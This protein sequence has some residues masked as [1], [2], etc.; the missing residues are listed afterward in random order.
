MYKKSVVTLLGAVLMVAYSFAQAPIS[1]FRKELAASKSDSQRL[2]TYIGLQEQYR[3]ANNDTYKV[4]IEEGIATFRE[5]EYKKGTAALLLML[6]GIH[7][8]DGELAAS[9]S[10]AGEA[11][12]IYTELNDKTGI[13]RTKNNLG[14]AA[15][16]QGEYD[17]AI[18]YFL[19][20]LK[21]FENI[22]D[23]ANIINSLV[24]LGAAND[25][26]GNY[27]KALSYYN[28]AL[29]L[30]T[31]IPLSG[32]TIYLYNNIGISHA[33]NG[34]LGKALWHF[35]KALELSADPK[36][37][38]TRI[39]PMKNVGNVY[40]EQGNIAK[41]LEYYQR[42]LV[43]AQ[44]GKVP[45]EY[46]E[47]LYLIGTIE[48]SE[49]P[50]NT[51]SMQD[52]LVLAREIDNKAMQVEILA[53]LAAATGE[54]GNYREQVSF[55]KQEQA[56][57]DSIFNIDKTREIANLE[58]RY[59]LEKSNAQLAK[60]KEAV[61]ENRQ[62]R[63]LI[64]IVSLV[65][66]AISL[67]LLFFYNKSRKLNIE[68][69]SR[70]QE[71]QDANLVKDRLFSII[72]H[73]LKGPI[74]SI[75]VLLDI[76]KNPETAK[77]ERSFILESLQENAKASMDT[78]DKLLNWG[79]LQIKGNGIHQSVCNMGEIM[80][81]KLRLF[82][83]TAENKNIILVNNIP[84][85]TKV[86]ADENQ[87]KFII[88]NLVSNAIKFTHP[89][90]RIE[91]G[92]TSHPEGNKIIFCVKDTGIGIPREKQAKIFE[93]ANT[94][95]AGTANE[96]GTSIGLMLCKEFV[97]QNGGRIWVESEAGKGATFYFTVNSAA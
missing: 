12:D 65:L 31:Q 55:L 38:R 26:L 23:T 25:Y 39:S 47:L 7:S 51:E 27:D 79:K 81:G 75:P 48:S 60:L 58:A 52:A 71:L 72:G 28:K 86:L 20:A 49:N 5:H 22:H 8:E 33:R 9:A 37:A 68:L 46:A 69:T 24:K 93:P 90:G 4:L 85:A 83:T 29:K 13:A 76:Y 50:R 56:L 36:Y 89:G 53:A 19:S 66:T 95:T 67:T 62:K 32:N 10:A 16:V 41:A 54:A 74:G 59:E 2:L 61:E 42:A 64:I 15:A 14:V 87:L 11:L 6:S 63:M 84:V 77:E 35:E 17:K 92:A 40:K 78:L 21:H 1:Q 3:N 70:Q 45:E 34:D 80:E 97:Q 43:L 73:D 18:N 94:S 82:R 30:S 96:S 88:R 91:V 57:R 44:D